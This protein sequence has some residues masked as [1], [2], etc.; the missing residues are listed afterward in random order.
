MDSYLTVAEA[1]GLVKLLFRPYEEFRIFWLALSDEEKEVY[2]RKSTAQIDEQIYTGRKAD[3]TQKR[4]FP[5]DFE[6]ELFTEL[7]EAVV[8]NALGF[9]NAD[10]KAVSTKQMKTLE[11]LGGLRNVKYDK[12]E[13]LAVSAEGYVLGAGANACAL[14]SR[15]AFERLKKYRLGGFKVRF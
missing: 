6:K 13:S 11:S 9:M 15:L 8:Y 4:Q 12:R 1:D 2:L 5:R 3:I 7:K 10:F 14:N